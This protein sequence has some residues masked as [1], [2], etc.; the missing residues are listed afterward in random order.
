MK[1]FVLFGQDSRIA[2]DY[3]PHLVYYGTFSSLENA[4]HWVSK[5]MKYNTWIE[6]DKLLVAYG[7][8]GNPINYMIRTE[9]LDSMMESIR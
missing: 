7:I 3:D 1:L 5:T 9:T 6:E 4:K 2:N 8:H